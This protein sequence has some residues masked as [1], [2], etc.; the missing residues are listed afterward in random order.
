M[1][2]FNYPNLPLRRKQTTEEIEELRGIWLIN[3]Q[4]GKIRLYSTYY[5]C[6][7]QACI[8]WSLLVLPMFIVAQFFAVSW[9]LQAILWSIISSIGVISMIFFAY[10]WAAAKQITWLLYCWSC[11]IITGLILTDLSIF[12]GWGQLLI[13][14]CPLWLLLSAIGYLC[15]GFAVRSRAFLWTA[16]AH[17]LVIF[18]L[19]YISAW[20]FIFT[21]LFTASCLLI[22]AEFQWDIL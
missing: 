3:W 13:N 11:L 22:L 20:Q 5:T 18:I 4:I 9:V 6:V 19:P 2:L 21:G 8:I 15:T 1:R 17:V 12:L 16:I 10:N 7:D 14:L